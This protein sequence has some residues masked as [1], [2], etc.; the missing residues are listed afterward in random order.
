MFLGCFRA[1]H[2]WNSLEIPMRNR[3]EKSSL[4]NQRQPAFL[5]VRSPLHQHTCFDFRV[6]FLAFVRFIISARRKF[7]HKA[8]T[9]RP[10]KGLWGKL[11]AWGIHGRSTVIQWGN[12]ETKNFRECLIG[13]W[14][15]WS[16]IFGF[17]KGCYYTFILRQLQFRGTSC[18]NVSE[19]TGH[20]LGTIFSE[21]PIQIWICLSQFSHFFFTSK[22]HIVIQED[23]KQHIWWYSYW[24][25]P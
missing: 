17:E 19:T 4:R 21:K 22:Q 13:N 15:T 20:F 24:K 16:D 11:I 25:L 8:L 7:K 18:I 2:V 1:L 6:A 10:G 23:F 3:H 14:P 12:W 5:M 9:M